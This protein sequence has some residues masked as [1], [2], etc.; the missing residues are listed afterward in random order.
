MLNAS[1]ANKVKKVV[2]TSSILSMSY[3]KDKKKLKFNENDWS[4]LD[5][6]KNYSYPNSKTQAE[7]FVWEFYEKNKDKIEITCI[8][9]A[10][11]QG[12]TISNRLYQ[13]HSYIIELMEN[14]HPMY[15]KL[16]ITMVNIKDVALAHIR[17]I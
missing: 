5:L 3:T 10:L 15:A 9:P 16:S 11:I 7:K 8:N 1:L 4:D 2:V 17:A 14:V 13:S 6:I 12:K